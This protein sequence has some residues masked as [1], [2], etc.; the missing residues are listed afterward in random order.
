MEAITEQPAP[1]ISPAPMS[2]IS[3]GTQIFTAAIPSLPTPCPTKI[4]S[5]VVTADI[6]NIPNRVGKNS[7]LNR[8]ETF[9]FPKSIT[10]SFIRLCILCY[11]VY[12][13]QKMTEAG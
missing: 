6:L 7:F 5:M 3:R 1:I 11:M 2:D 4:P 8:M 13:R 10:F 12:L 9:S